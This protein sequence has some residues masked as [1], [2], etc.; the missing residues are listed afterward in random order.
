MAHLEQRDHDGVHE[1]GGDVPRRGRA[2]VG[3]LLRVRARQQPV[4]GD[5]RRRRA[6]PLRVKAA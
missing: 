1:L 4:E 6:R 3:V 2:W 5:A